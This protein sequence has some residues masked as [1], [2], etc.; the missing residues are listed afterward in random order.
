[1]DAL[2]TTTIASDAIIDIKPGSN[3]NPIHNKEKLVPVAILGS[4]NFDV[5]NVDIAT[6]TFGPGE[7][8]PV[9]LKNGQL[10]PDHYVDVNG[11]GYLDLVAHFQT[12]EAGLGSIDVEQACLLGKTFDG[13]LFGD[14]DLLSYPGNK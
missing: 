6:L 4:A 13:S 3:K 8:A 10:P 9:H 2:E 7:A 14:C 1:M 5:T 11:D 12:L